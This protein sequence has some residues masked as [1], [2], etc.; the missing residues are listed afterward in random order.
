MWMVQKDKYFDYIAR[1]G[2]RIGFDV[3]DVFAGKHRNFAVKVS[4]IDSGKGVWA[5]KFQGKN[6]L[7]KRSVE[8]QG[9]GRVKTATFFINSDFQSKP[10]AF[11]IEIQGEDGFEPTLSFIRI[12]KV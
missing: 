1:K 4:Y 2:K 11:D 9:T 3:D 5:L 8:C 7:E 10:T 6:G 12:I